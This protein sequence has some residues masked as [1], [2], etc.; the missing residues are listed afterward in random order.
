MFRIHIV[1][2]SP[3]NMGVCLHI[4]ADLHFHIDQK[5]ERQNPAIG[6]GTLISANLIQQMASVQLNTFL[7][8]LFMEAKLNC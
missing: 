3:M 6:M 5:G 7:R 8:Y 1:N 2:M 4:Q